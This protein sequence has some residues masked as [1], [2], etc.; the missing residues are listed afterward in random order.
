MQGVGSSPAAIKKGFD[1][2]SGNVIGDY[3]SLSPS[4]NPNAIKQEIKTMQHLAKDSS[5]PG[6]GVNGKK[7]LLGSAEH[8][9]GIDKGYAAFY[10]KH[11]NKAAAATF[12]T[13]AN[14]E[15]ATIKKIEKQ[16]GI[17]KYTFDGNNTPPKNNIA[18]KVKKKVP[19]ENF[20]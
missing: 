3:T 7:H 18:P 14:K 9:Y 19:G 20:K 4:T 8:A 15:R 17:E 2:N 12:S 10:K 5:D 16:R 11:G 1:K 6:R 13:L